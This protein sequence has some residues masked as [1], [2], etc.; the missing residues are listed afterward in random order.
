MVPLFLLPTEQVS[1]PEIKVLNKTQENE[2]GTCSLLLACTVKKGDH[3][4]YSWSD[5]AGTHLLS[6]ANRSHL[7]HITLSN[8]H[9]DSIYNC[10]ASN[11]VSSISR[12]FNLSS[13]AC[14]QESS[15]GDHWVTSSMANPLLTSPIA[16]LQQLSLAHDISC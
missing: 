12:T 15:S 13:Q 6:R 4:T 7:L 3:V 2:N 14:K 1:P 10:T 9:Q 5:E 16:L 11:P 8:Q